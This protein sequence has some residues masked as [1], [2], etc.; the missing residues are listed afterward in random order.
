MDLPD[1]SVNCA[2][3]RTAARPVF[4]NTMTFSVVR[5]P[6]VPPEIVILRSATAEIGLGLIVGG[7]KVVRVAVSGGGAAL[8]SDDNTVSKT[9]N[10]ALL[11]Q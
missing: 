8:R 11:I 4:R 1:G 10:I 2:V 6:A 5:C 9:P 7:T 3:S